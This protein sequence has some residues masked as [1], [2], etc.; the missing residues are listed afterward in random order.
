[1]PAVGA[2]DMAALRERAAAFWAA[3]VAGDP[4]AQVEDAAVHGYFAEVRIRLLVQPALPSERAGHAIGP[5]VTV[6]NDGWVKIRGVWYRRLDAGAEMPR[7]G[8][9]VKD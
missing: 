7:T 2:T 6:L 3:R 4:E 9:P 5:Q 8:E 1:M